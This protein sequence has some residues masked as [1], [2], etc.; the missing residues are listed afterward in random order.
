M[1]TYCSYRTSGHRVA[2][3]LARNIVHPG[4]HQTGQVQVV[5]GFLKYLLAVGMLTSWWLLPCQTA[6]AARPQVSAL[7]DLLDRRMRVTLS[8]GRVITGLFKVRMFAVV[9]MVHCLGL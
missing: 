8:D 9:C 5:G 3:G 2:R 4:W 6:D 7:K 1:I